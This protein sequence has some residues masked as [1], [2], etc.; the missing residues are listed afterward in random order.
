MAFLSKIEPKSIEDA[1][2][3]ENWI[4]AMQEELNQFDRNCV[5]KLV[6]KPKDHTIIGT[7]WVFRNKLNEYGNVVQNK[8]ILVAKGCNQEKGINFDN[9][10]APVARPEAI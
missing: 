6:P 5:Q 4:M 9:T 10:F 8:A 3:D 2:E 1:K 7:K